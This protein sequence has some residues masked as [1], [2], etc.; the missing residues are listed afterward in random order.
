M[1]HKIHYAEAFELITCIFTTSQFQKVKDKDNL[2]VWESTREL[3]AGG[4]RS[5]WKRGLG[6]HLSS[7]ED[8]A[9]PLQ[10]YNASLICMRLFQGKEYHRKGD[11]KRSKIAGYEM[12][13]D[14]LRC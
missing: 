7:G 6:C 2:Q 4:L 11:L 8:S 9:P 3:G 10:Q 13:V 5:I 12:L 14:P 1:H